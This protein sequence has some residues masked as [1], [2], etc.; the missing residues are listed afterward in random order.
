MP[1]RSQLCAKRA[2]IAPGSMRS[3]RTRAQGARTSDRARVVGIRR[4]SRSVW[5]V[6]VVSE[7][8]G[9]LSALQIKWRAVF[10]KIWG[11]VEGFYIRKL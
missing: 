4:L 9:V 1:S 2:T 7:Y 11:E 8:S 6:V 10:D 3:R 5:L